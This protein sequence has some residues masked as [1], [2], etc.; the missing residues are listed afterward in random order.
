MSAFLAAQF[1]ELNKPT[2]LLI[3]DILQDYSKLET[4]TPSNRDTHI[5]SADKLHMYIPNSENACKNV[6]LF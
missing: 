3:S 6:S 1:D 2:G 5:F 4:S